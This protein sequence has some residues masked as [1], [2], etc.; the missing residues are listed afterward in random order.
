MEKIKQALESEFNEIQ[1]EVKTLNQRKS[2]SE[3]CRKK[4]E[5]QLRELQVKYEDTDRQKQDSLEKM[6][7]L[8]VGF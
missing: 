4:A 8:Q 6:A 3:H 5:A 2:D 1:I 7:K